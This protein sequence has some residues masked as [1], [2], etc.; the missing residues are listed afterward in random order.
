ME[1]YNW[2]ELKALITKEARSPFLIQDILQPQSINIMVG[3]WG[4][5][6]S[7]FAHQLAIALAAGLP[8][9]MNTYRTMSEPLRVLYCDFENSRVVTNA[10]IESVSQFQGLAEPPT[11]LRIAQPDTIKE[12]TEGIGDLKSQFVVIDP[13]RILWPK[14]EN[15]TETA[16]QFIAQQRDW[17]KRF[18]VTILTIH[19]PRKW[20]GE[21]EPPSLAINPQG[22]LQEASGNSALIMN[23]DGRHGFQESENDTLVFRS[24]L[25]GRG[26]SLPLHLTRVCDDEGEPLGYQLVQG[27]NQLEPEPLARFSQLDDTYFT[28]DHKA[29]FN[30]IPFD[31]VI[32]RER[33]H[34]LQLGLIQPG[35]RRG[36]W[37]KV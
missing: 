28:S 16:M 15:E 10:I 24:F 12:L 35:S 33:D 23:S 18:G 19:H 14:A 3:H 26:W 36:Q 30:P 34:W 13:L 6:K 32:K 11:S 29:L 22:F 17:I 7:P 27:I 31:M 4:I 21:G 8:L 25:R 5:G 37:V 1:S 2:L 9:F 20:T